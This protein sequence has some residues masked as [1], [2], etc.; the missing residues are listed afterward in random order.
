[1]SNAPVAAAPTIEDIMRMNKKYLRLAARKWSRC[2]Q[3]SGSAIVQTWVA[4]QPLVFNVPTVQDGYLEGFWVYVNGVV[5]PATGTSAVYAHNAGSPLNIFDSIQ[6]KYNGNHQDLRPH[7]LRT[8]AMLSGFQ[9]LPVPSVVIAGQ[10]VSFVNAY[11]NSGGSSS[12]PLTVNTD[13]SWKFGFFIPLN[14]SNPYDARG[15]LPIQ[16]GETTAQLQLNCAPSLSGV[17]PI[18]NTIAFASG[19][20]HSLRGAG[21]AGV[22]AFSIYV[23]AAYRDGDSL[24]GPGKLPLQIE[25]IGTAQA[26]RD[27]N[28][29]LTGIGIGNIARGRIGIQGQHRLILATVVDGN[30]S[31]KFAANSNIVALE[32]A[33]DSN[34][35]TPFFR[36]GSLTNNPMELFWMNLRDIPGAEA[37]LGQDIDE[38]II[39]VVNG[40][41]FG[42]H[43]AGNSGMGQLYADTSPDTGWSDL[44]FGV[45]LTSSGAVSGIQP[46]IEFQTWYLTNRSL[47]RVG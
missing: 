42:E 7:T 39:P 17:D 46:R 25:G 2:V 9:A 5:N 8:R 31:N 38:G 29:S 44:H 14:W 15:M 3:A 21:G 45:Q 33:R 36:Y 16:Y 47:Q 1:M 35:Q 23:Q 37:P 40:L 12:M 18:L 10:A 26:A 11:A 13:N 41:A 20:G 24:I 4:G 30:Q 19:T 32:I 28:L 6:V 34:G 27:N 22:P 43:D